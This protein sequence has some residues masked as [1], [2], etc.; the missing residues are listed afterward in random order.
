MWAPCMLGFEH[1]KAGAAHS[2]TGF[3]F[4]TRRLVAVTRTRL[5][6]YAHFTGKGPALQS[7]V[8]LCYVGTH[9]GL[10]TAT[11]ERMI[12]FPRNPEFVQ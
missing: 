9:C 8:L 7:I 1:R 6:I 11:V 3:V 4:Q 10:A 5:R 2:P 12:C